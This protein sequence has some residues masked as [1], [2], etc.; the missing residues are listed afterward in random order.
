MTATVLALPQQ[1]GIRFAFGITRECMAGAEIMIVERC[2]D[3]SFFGDPGTFDFVAK[4]EAECRAKLALWG[5]T[6]L[7]SENT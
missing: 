4:D 3:G 7:V 5:Y 2:A 1:P 6:V